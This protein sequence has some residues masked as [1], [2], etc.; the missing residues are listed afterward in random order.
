MKRINGINIFLDKSII[1]STNFYK[2]EN[3]NY[4]DTKENIDKVFYAASLNKKT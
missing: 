3:G 4:A 2:L 1:S